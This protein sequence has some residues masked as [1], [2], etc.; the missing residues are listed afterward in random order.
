MA[1][2]GS[3]PTRFSTLKAWRAT[4][5]M[6]KKVGDRWEEYVHKRGAWSFLVLKNETRFAVICGHTAFVLLRSLTF[7]LFHSQ[8][9]WLWAGLRQLPHTQPQ[10]SRVKCKRLE[11]LTNPGKIFHRFFFFAAIIKLTLLFLK[12]MQNRASGVDNY[13]FAL[14]LSI[15][16]HLL[17]AALNT[18]DHKILIRSPTVICALVVCIDNVWNEM[19]YKH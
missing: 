12:R 17:S 3:G 19:N 6:K 13:C 7:S 15:F 10:R 18:A 5:R 11:Y 4:G 9:I 2:K 1:R 8:L 14:H 16:K